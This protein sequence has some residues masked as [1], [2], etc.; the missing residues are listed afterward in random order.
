M[1]NKGLE[2]LSDEKNETLKYD[3]HSRNHMHEEDKP[4]AV[5]FNN[6]HATAHFLALLSLFFIIIPPLG[7]L[8]SLIAQRVAHTTK[9]ER[10]RTLALVA[11]ILNILILIII[12]LL[13]VFFREASLALMRAQ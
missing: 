5:H 8:V 12:S 11:L 1:I 4:P 10:A 6:P 3:E 2:E 13:Y 7:I 9:N